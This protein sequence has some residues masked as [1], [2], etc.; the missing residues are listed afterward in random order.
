MESC[1]IKF[2]EIEIGYTIQQLQE[3]RVSP[4]MTIRNKNGCGHRVKK[5]DLFFSILLI[6]LTS[7]KRF[8]D[9]SAEKCFLPQQLPDGTLKVL[10]MGS[11]NKALLIWVI[12]FE[13]E[14]LILTP[15]NS[16]LNNI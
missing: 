9:S 16:E 3:N 7:S 4:L 13:F 6:S 12:C 1:E 5:N 8:S 2:D 11:Y 15:S 10:V 14:S